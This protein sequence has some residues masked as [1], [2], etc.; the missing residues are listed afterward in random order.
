[1]K[2]VLGVICLNKGLFMTSQ[3]QNVCQIEFEATNERCD[4]HC[5]YSYAPQAIGGSE[6]NGVAKRST[7]TSKRVCSCAKCVFVSSVAA[8]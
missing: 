2:I 6:E 5:C 4:I 1:M 3:R 8:V 7:L